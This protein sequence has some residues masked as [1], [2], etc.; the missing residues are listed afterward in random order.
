MRPLVFVCVCVGI[1]STFQ[2]HVWSFGAGSEDTMYEKFL[3][4]YAPTRMPYAI[5][6]F[7]L[8]FRLPRTRSDLTTYRG[9]FLQQNIKGPLQ[10]FPPPCLARKSNCNKCRF[11]TPSNSIPHFPTL[12]VATSIQFFNQGL[13]RLQPPRP[14]QCSIISASLVLRR[15]MKFLLQDNQLT[16]SETNIFGALSFRI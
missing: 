10:S 5:G 13:T 16:R 12:R 7:R 6:R 1:S 8:S 11:S 15:V 3:G 14:P 2:C 4:S 9:L